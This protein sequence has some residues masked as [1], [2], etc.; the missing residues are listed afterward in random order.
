MERNYETITD[1][2][3]EAN[4][5]CRNILEVAADVFAGERFRDSDMFAV[6]Q[7]RR[8]EYADDM[9]CSISF[10]ASKFEDEAGAVTISYD[11]EVSASRPFDES[12]Y[13]PGLSENLAGI[14]AHSTEADYLDESELVRSIENG[15]IDTDGWGVAEVWQFIID[16]VN[17]QPRKDIRWEYYDDE[18]ELVGIVGTNDAL[19]VTRALLEQPEEDQV[20]KHI[21]YDMSHSFS[22]QDVKEILGVLE[23]FNIYI[24]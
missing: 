10:E 19:I 13:W 21:E 4:N 3:I 14:D 7:T 9:E 17:L 11:I 24:S 16:D 1:E 15:E 2:S 8:I 18:G 12:F 20:L 5:L 22:S 6:N 23:K